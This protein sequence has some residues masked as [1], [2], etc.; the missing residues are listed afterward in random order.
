M[1]VIEHCVFKGSE[2]LQDGD[3]FR[4]T[5]LMG[6]DTN[7]STD[8]AKIDYFISAPY[9]PKNNLAKTIEIQGDMLSTPKF[10]QNAIRSEILGPICSE[11]SMIND[12]PATIA[13]DELL[14]NLFQI[15]TS[16][17]NLVAGSID[18]V[19]N[20]SRED[21]VKQHQTC[22]D[23]ENMYTIVVGDVD[24]DKTINLISNNFTLPAKGI[25]DKRPTHESINP[26]Q[27]S[28]REDIRSSKTNNTTV[29][30]AFEGP[31]AKDGKDF[32]IEQMIDYYLSQCST[33]DLKNNLEKIN[34]GYSSTVQ[35]VGTDINHPRALISVL[36]L[37]PNEEQK[38]LDI[39]YDA[40]QKLQNSPLSD[41]DMQAIK[42]NVLKNIEYGACD[43][44]ALCNMLGNNLIDNTLY[45][46]SNYKEL[47]QNITKEDIMNFARKYYNLNKAS[48]VVV[49]PSKVSS[50]EIQ[51]NYQG[52][53]YSYMNVNQAKS[54]AFTGNKKIST[55]G[56]K[57]VKLPNNTHLAINPT[58]QNL[59]VFNWNVNTPPI[60]PK[61][62][63]I[64]AVLR[65]MFEKGSEY[66]NQNEIERFKELNGIDI[67]TYVNGKGIEI[68]ADCMPQDTT[69][70]LELM[71]ELMYHPKLTQKDFEDAKRYVK[72]ML[73]T[74][75]K[76]A[77]S[78]LLDKLYPGFFPTDAT[79]LKAIDKL[80]L[81]DVKEF[82][83]E[84]LKNASSSFVATIPNKKYPTLEQEVLNNQNTTN[85]K[86]K[87]NVPKLTPIFEANPKANVIYDTDDL[88]QAQIY[89]SYK[90]PLSGNIEDEAKFELVNTILGATP[91]AR[92]FSDLRDKQNLAYSVSSSI[93]SFEN[94]GIVTLKIQTTTDNKEAGVESYDNVQKSLD[95][96]K[97]HTDLLCNE[98]VGDEELEA[99]KTRLKQNIIGQCQNPLSE[100]GLLAMNILEP[101]GIKRIDKY[102][103]AIEK[104]TK[105][106]IMKASQF[107][108]SHEPTISILASADTINSQMSYLEKQG[109]I[110]KVES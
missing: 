106:D 41:N 5:N 85:V 22:Y 101:Y 74:S 30:L 8:M 12:D 3:V 102:I 26:I 73:L 24:V 37:N 89:K 42:K 93:Q 55:E 4:L 48:I 6:A 90:F 36:E 39:F 58:N 46:F 71:N 60:K 17:E 97:K 92:L 61:N 98:L 107:I 34:A 100:T 56:V 29:F 103:E 72:D 99:A 40:I 78:N 80:T 91:N 76:D 94:T 21:V 11:I 69:K 35:K 45:T 84:L 96:F 87:E 77:T 20:L 110:Q 53:K 28:K 83:N 79:M 1:H 32:I 67:S 70:T 7:A 9:M 31:K 86:F 54:I 38:G 2:K 75:Q 95:G 52:S 23:P 65:Y 64:P 66:K 13:Y 68:T 25:A 14:K 27:A 19:K 50:E 82:Y 59:C 47:A 51:A 49:H 109:E 10:E 81:E 57:E 88:N 15:Q 105:E 63:N 108:F 18:T 104:V 62:P 16:S 44:E 33:S 43:S